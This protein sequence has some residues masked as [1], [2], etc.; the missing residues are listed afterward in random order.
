MRWHLQLLHQ[1]IHDLHQRQRRAWQ[2]CVWDDRTLH[3]V[4]IGTCNSLR[5]R[6]SPQGANAETLTASLAE[7]MCAL[8]CGR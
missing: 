6:D 2:R 1:K 4:V 7:H 8:V 3:L 5:L